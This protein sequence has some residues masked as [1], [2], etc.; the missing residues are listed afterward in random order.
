MRRRSVKELSRS[1][2]RVL[3]LVLSAFRAFG[4]LSPSI[5]SFLLRFLLSGSRSGRRQSSEGSR[6]GSA[7]LCRAAESHLSSI[8]CESN[9]ALLRSA[10]LSLPGS[11]L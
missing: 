8:A 2:S 4:R 1:T 7:L 10:E 3:D 11:T 9:S 6:A 5:R